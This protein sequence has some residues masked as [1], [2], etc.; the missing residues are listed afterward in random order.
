MVANSVR[1]RSWRTRQ[2]VYCLSTRRSSWTSSTDLWS[3]NKGRII[4]SQP[5]EEPTGTS[6]GIANSLNP[7]QPALDTVTTCNLPS[8]HFDVGKPSEDSR[9]RKLTFQEV[10]K[11]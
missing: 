2:R 6:F 1:F 4:R 3:R 5:S 9:R 10:L 11:A 8:Y 7:G